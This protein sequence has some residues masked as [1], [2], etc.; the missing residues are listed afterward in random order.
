MNGERLVRSAVREEAYCSWILHQIGLTDY[1][2]FDLEA[3]W[4]TAST[5]DLTVNQFIEEY[6]Q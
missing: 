1:T 5:S 3:L 6:A 2:G 4:E